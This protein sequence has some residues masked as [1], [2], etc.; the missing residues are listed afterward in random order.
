M[1]ARVTLVNKHKASKEFNGCHSCIATAKKYG[2]A[3]NTISNW[4]KKKVEIFEKVEGK[5]V[6]KKRKRM[7]TAT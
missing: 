2:A 6:S 5:N 1:F 7:K 4:L 3:K